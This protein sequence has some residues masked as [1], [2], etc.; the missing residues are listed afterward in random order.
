LVH[1]TNRLIVPVNDAFKEVSIQDGKAVGDDLPNSIC[2]L[3]DPSEGFSEDETLANGFLIAAAPALY[4]ALE[5]CRAKFS[6][7]AEMHRAKIGTKDAD[8]PKK[9]DA[10]LAKVERNLEMA[11]LC[12]AALAQAR[13]EAL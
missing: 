7:Y 4:E 12:E 13:G 3:R 1:A 6:V 11:A 5:R 9:M 2:L 8:S 10:V